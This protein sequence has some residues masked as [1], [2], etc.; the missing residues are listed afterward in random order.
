MPLTYVEAGTLGEPSKIEVRKGGL[1][2]GRILTAPN[3][4]FQFFKG[5]DDIFAL[6]P[7]V[8]NSDLEQLKKWL[9]E[10]F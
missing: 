9:A 4:T 10:H 1:L 6:N 3:G 7:I 5:S 8:E 2:I